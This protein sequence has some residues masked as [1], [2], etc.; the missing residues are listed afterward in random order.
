VKPIIDTAQVRAWVREGGEIALRSFHHVEAT[1]KADNT[2]VTRVDREIEAL[3]SARIRAAYPDHGLIGEEGA[4]AGPRGAE[5]LWA[6]D[7]ID[8]TRAFVQ[9]LP[10]WGVAIGV[11]YRG[12]PMWGM[13]YMP[14]LDDWTYTEGTQG[15]TWNGHELSPAG[16]LR[17]GAL[18]SEWDDQ[19]FLAISSTAHHDYKIGVKRTRALGSMAANMVYTARGAALGAF[20]AKGYVW[21]LVAGAA[22]LL[23]LGA[24]LEYLS[25]R[26][27][28]W[29]ALADG[30]M[31]PEP[32]LAAHPA[33]MERIRG[34]IRKKEG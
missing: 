8:G 11:L 29:G 30:R 22:I 18:R 13:F 25:G 7:P 26:A 28:D 23:R 1:R 34:L 2:F 31:I 4:R 21:D 3:L 17:G 27:I 14:L 15:V 20:M 19:S 5:V 9:G 10:G 6:V 12:E 32:I 33:L 16:D 24:K